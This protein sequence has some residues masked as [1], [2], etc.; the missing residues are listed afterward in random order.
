MK[1]HGKV[2]ER[3]P[4]RSYTANCIPNRLFRSISLLS[5]LQDPPELGR[6]QPSQVPFWVGSMFSGDPE[7]QQA[8][9]QTQSAQA[10]IDMVRLTL[11][12]ALKH[13]TAALAI[14]SVFS[15]PT[16]EDPEQDPDS[17]IKATGDSGETGSSD[18]GD[19]KKP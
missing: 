9:L 7:G 2:M 11:S 8:L 14:E 4:F 3:I 15:S 6:L 16:A 13:T 5:L 19:Q 10:R 12:E 17:A 1:I 18:S